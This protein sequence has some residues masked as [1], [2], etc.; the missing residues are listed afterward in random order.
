[1]EG[2][3]LTAGE[4]LLIVGAVIVLV[5][6]GSVWAGAFLSAL[7]SG[8]H[9]DATFSMALDA[10]VTLPST[11]SDPALAWPAEV[12]GVLPGTVV[13]WMAT[14]IAALVIVTAI[15]MA[16]RLFRHRVGTVE[17]RPLGVDAR[18]RFASRRDLAPLLIRKAEPG[19]FIV[20]RF[21]RRLVA[22]EVPHHGRGRRGRPRPSRGGHPGRG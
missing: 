3:G 13:Y 20:G 14:A 22:T 17:R 7:V 4:T 10:A 19:R 1:M 18:A 21:G 2:N 11:A 15:A 6:G 8:Q 16:V 9:L 12:R 5:V